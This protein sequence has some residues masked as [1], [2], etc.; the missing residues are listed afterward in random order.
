MNS[1]RT[2]TGFPSPADDYLE[3]II[4]LNKA[5]I[6]NPSST[7]YG[8][9]VGN[10]MLESS[11]SPDDIVVID[12]SLEPW[13]NDIVVCYLEGAFTMRRVKKDK[14]GT[15]LVSERKSKAIL[16][17][18]EIEFLLWGVVTYIFKKSR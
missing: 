17:T 13:N 16:L 8:R 9:V 14:T 1:A 11:I 10:S 15:W 18:P 4:D 6:K 7:F 12:K 3:D 2:H 5:V